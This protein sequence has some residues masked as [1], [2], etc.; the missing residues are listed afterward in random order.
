MTYFDLTLLQL[1]QWMARC[2]RLAPPPVNM[3]QYQV[4]RSAIR[5]LHNCIDI[6]EA[7]FIGPVWV[8]V[9]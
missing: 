3:D 2:I 8:C 5:V 9:L 7:Q 1:I 6:L 4:V